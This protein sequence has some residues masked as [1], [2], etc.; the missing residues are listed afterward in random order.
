MQCIKYQKTQQA[1]NCRSGSRECS[2]KT[3]DHLSD[4]KLSHNG[5][6]VDDQCI[7]VGLFF[8]FSIKCLIGFS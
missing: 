1:Q 3:M 4:S 7:K 5:L 8:F 2:V 6:E